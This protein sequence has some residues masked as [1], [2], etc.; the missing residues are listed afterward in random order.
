MI[1]KDAHILKDISNFW[2][3]S[4]TTSPKIKN[5][6]LEIKPYLLWMSW[7]KA[8][9]VNESLVGMSQNTADEARI[10][11]RVRWGKVLRLT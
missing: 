6:R 7:N 9:F 5:S 1:E 3:I 11:E 8:A 4:G 10:Y 2:L